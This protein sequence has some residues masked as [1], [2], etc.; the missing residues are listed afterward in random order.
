M[1]TTK[2]FRYANVTATLALV[3]ALGGTGYALSLE[4]GSVGAREIAEDAVRSHHVK[5]GQI[6]AKDLNRRF[7]ASILSSPE[8]FSVSDTTPTSVPSGSTFTKLSSISP[9]DVAGAGAQFEDIIISGVVQA[10]NTSPS[11]SMG[12]LTLGIID[13]S[14]GEILWLTTATIVGGHTA[15]IPIQ[16]FHTSDENVGTETLEFSLEA[17]AQGQGIVIEREQLSIF[18]VELLEE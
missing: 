13:V 18:D 12:S 1:G 10:T 16:G 8:F 15:T 5:N 9:G 14:T 6:V 2:T 17:Q 11:G 3:V 7:A 4:K